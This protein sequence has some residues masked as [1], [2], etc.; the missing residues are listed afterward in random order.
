[1]LPI[2]REYASRS[3]LVIALLLAAC[4]PPALELPQPEPTKLKV[5]VLPYLSYGPLFIA[6]EEGY[7]AEQGLE[8]EFVKMA[9]S[10]EAIPALAQGDLDV[11]GAIVSVGLLNA[12][13]K[14]GDIRF[15]AD[16]AHI[17]PTGC[18][19]MA[20]MARRALVE[21][22]QLD[23]PAGLQGYQTSVQP[24]S[25]SSYLVEKLLNTVGMTLDD[26]DTVDVM[27]PVELEAFETGALD[28]AAASEPW[29]TRMLQAGHAVDWVPAQQVIPGFQLTVIAYGP[30]LIDENPDAGKRFMTAYLKAVRQLNEGKT[31]RNLDLLAEF[32]GLDRE[33]LEQTCWPST[34][35]DG[36]INVQSVVDFQS[37][38]LE[39]GYLDN[40][41]TEEQLWDPSFI[42]YANEVLGAPSQ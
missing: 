37:W 39:N 14:G 3:C 34:H 10:T 11:L 26:V 19:Y 18:T 1:M 8:I 13:A 24:S 29:V 16:V 21:A 9:R 38:A 42:D 27:D 15:V 5:V 30:T 25:I 36:Q 2:L 17:N 41:V 22:G 28:A 32:T 7:Y 6:E 20:V 12:M 33:V 35:P 40:P 23:S 4:A 31:E